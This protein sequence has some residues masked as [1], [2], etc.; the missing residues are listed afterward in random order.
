MKR[1]IEV[2]E[3]SDF[4]FGVKR[5]IHLAQ[6]ALRKY[7]QPVFSLGPLIHN[8]EVVTRLSDKGL[9]VRR[10]YSSI[11]RGT[12][13]TRSHGIK[14]DVL[15]KIQAKRISIVDA[16]CPFVKNAQMI[17][18]RLAGEGY[19]VVIV[20]DKGHPE[21]KSLMSYSPRKV[22]VVANRNDASRLKVDKGKIGVVSQTTQ[23]F[24]NFRNVMDEL[25][26]K[27][28]TE[29][30]MFNTICSD[31]SMRQMAAERC[32]KANE[33][34]IVVGGRNSANTKKLREICDKQGTSSYHI[35]NK[36]EIDPKWLRGKSR[37]GIV[38]GA[39][40][41]RWIVDDVVKRLKEL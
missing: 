9:R 36:E 29:I 38:S 41:P 22:A 31:V 37:I 21:V 40:T 32:S 26:K 16:T 34:V 19:F 20:G 23:S 15:K 11:K 27:K 13:V 18:K 33:V 17:T 30:R 3:F 10:D 28:F 35:E 2:S 6:E 1:K 39:S 12:I 24:K 7:P 5:A 25:M 8:R 14:S 4:C